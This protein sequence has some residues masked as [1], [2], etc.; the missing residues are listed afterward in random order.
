MSSTYKRSSRNYP[1][2]AST[3]F[4]CDSS[5]DHQTISQAAALSLML[6]FKKIMIWHFSSKQVCSRSSDPCDPG[7]PGG[8]SVPGDPQGEC[9][10]ECIFRYNKG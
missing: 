2:R 1:I 4:D 7:G 3:D 5:V 10:C 9:E 8:K 6:L